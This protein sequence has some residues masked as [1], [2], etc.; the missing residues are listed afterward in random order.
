MVNQGQIEQG[1]CFLRLLDW[2]I[3][4]KTLKCPTRS[5][6]PKREKE[7]KHTGF[8]SDHV[9]MVTFFIQLESNSSQQTGEIDMVKRDS[10]EKS[11]EGSTKT[12][13][14]QIRVGL[15]MTE[16]PWGIITVHLPWLVNIIAFL[17]LK[18]M[19]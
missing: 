17:Y 5:T 4:R 19:T 14:G 9:L 15:P 12:A 13:E 16:R 10:E 3:L 8:F 18:V 2:K 1:V 11:R 6:D 7:K